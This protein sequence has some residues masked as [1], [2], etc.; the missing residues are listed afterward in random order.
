MIEE[1]LKFTEDV[2]GL[3]KS[4]DILE[5]M[6]ER[7]D[8]LKDK[9]KELFEENA[10]QAQ[11]YEDSLKDLTNKLALQAQQIQNNKRRQDRLNDSTRKATNINR[12][13][14]KTA[15]QFTKRLV[16]QER[17]M[18]IFGKGIT[19]VIGKLKL[20]RVAFAATGIG[21]FILLVGGLVTALANLE[22]IGK[23]INNT[24]TAISTTFDILLN[25]GDKLLNI[26]KNIITLNFSDAANELGE[27][28]DEIV[29]TTLKAIELQEAFD[30]LDEF[31]SKIA[32]E[33][34]KTN[35]ALAKNKAAQEDVNTSARERLKLIKEAN[36][37]ESSNVLFIKAQKEERLELSEIELGNTRDKEK[38][39]K[40]E[41]R[42]AELQIEI[43]KLEQDEVGILTATRRAR[44]VVFDE[45]RRA[46][47]KRQKELEKE[48]KALDKINKTLK[49]QV[50]E[51]TQAGLSDQARL[52][53]QRE[54]ALGELNDLEKLALEK[55][56]KVQASEE[57]I[58]KLRDDFNE[59]RL[60]TEQH[61]AREINDLILKQEKKL[62][63]DLK[64][65]TD[66]FLSERDRT[67]NNRLNFIKTEEEL[68]LKEL[69]LVKSFNDDILTDDQVREAKRIQIQIQSLEK[70]K[71]ILEEFNSD[72]NSIR[73][74][75]IDIE[76][77]QSQ[78]ERIVDP[79]LSVFDRIGNGFKKIFNL[80]DADFALIK[81]Q[82]G[83]AFGNI[84]DGF[85]ANNDRLL[86]EN[87][88]LI[89]ALDKEIAVIEEKLQVELDRE[90]EG[91]ANSADTLRKNLEEKNK[92]REEA[93]QKRL[94]IEKKAARQRLIRESIQQASSIVTAAASLLAAE[95]SKGLVGIITGLSGIALIFSAISKAKAQAAEFSK[96]VPQLGEGGALDDLFSGEIKGRSHTDGGV[97][98]RVGG[99]PIELE[100]REFVVNKKDAQEHKPFL[101]D[102]NNGAY[103]GKNIHDLVE[104][105][106]MFNSPIPYFVE[107]FKKLEASQIE[108][109]LK[110]NQM[111][112]E[113]IQSMNSEIK[114][115][116]D[117]IK[118]KP[119]VFPLSKGDKI[120]EQYGSGQN[121]SY[122]VKKVE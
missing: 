3:E 9:N 41:K 117:I 51:L 56:A 43:L 102:L 70:Q 107:S 24:M 10:K 54:V 49:Q 61:F 116:K 60:L 72:P 91:F 100:G 59:A 8:E 111:L 35:L 109:R 31:E 38:R 4:I 66:K 85:G 113:E 81:D 68:K 65:E 53:R 118:N 93:E 84:L 90:Q 48:Q 42:I 71:A 23:F 103:R 94:D 106:Q 86:A 27:L 87:Q 33:I 120:V 64:K 47:E 110:E 92:A 119:S 58:Q 37:M 73:A 12:G 69:E 28:K 18:A 19:R 97:P 16:V 32:V 62:L 78:L 21:A 2:S 36:D 76:L 34:E 80:S 96:D 82:L 67:R 77:L 6:A 14:L 26:F 115:L 101:F 22:T 122:N 75:E 89:N 88:R 55:A 83:T 46:A 121:A 1:T 99:K 108:R 29:E 30:I 74:F 45:Q 20:L 63:E 11:K 52:E 44:Q 7:I 5:T 79:A 104:R 95:A 98:G 50:E 57:D 114:E 25:S 105:G 40:I 39:E 17:A 13:V 112:K 15:S